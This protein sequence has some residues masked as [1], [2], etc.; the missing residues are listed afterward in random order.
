MAN[1]YTTSYRSKWPLFCWLLVKP[2]L[3]AFLS[4]SWAIST[5]MWGFGF[6]LSVAPEKEERNTKSSHVCPWSLRVRVCRRC[7]LLRAGHKDHINRAPGCF[8]LAGWLLLSIRP[9]TSS[10]PPSQVTVSRFSYFSREKDLHSPVSYWILQGASPLHPTSWHSYGLEMRWLHLAEGKCFQ[11]DS[12][13]TTTAGAHNSSNS[14]RTS[15][16]YYPDL[17]GI[18]FSK[19]FCPQGF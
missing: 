5:V 12:R 14:T 8:P 10:H 18:L 7:C 13:A 17:E 16:Y 6:S 2:F 1:W 4:R 11:L 3:R 9:A 15:H 19:H